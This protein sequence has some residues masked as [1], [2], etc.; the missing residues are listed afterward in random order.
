MTLLW[1]IAWLVMGLPPVHRW[2]AALVSL[3]VCVVI[4]LTASHR[5]GEL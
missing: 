3:V 5:R 1:L 2:N 4:D